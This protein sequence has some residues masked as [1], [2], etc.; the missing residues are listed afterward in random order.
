MVGKC[1]LFLG[2]HA[3]LTDISHWFSNCERV[4]FAGILDRREVRDSSTL[5]RKESR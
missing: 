2:E 3:A 1:D 4:N 5:E